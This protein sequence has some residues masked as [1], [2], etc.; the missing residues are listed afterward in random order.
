MATETWSKNGLAFFPDTCFYEFIP[1]QEMLRNL[2]DPSYQPRTY[3]MDQLSANENYELVITVLKGGSFVRY[4]PGDVYRCVRLKNPEDGLDFPQFQYMD[5][6]PTVIDI[7]GFTR[8][9]ENS[10]NHVFE[11]SGIRPADWF[12]LKK[13]D[14][15]KRSYLQMYVELSDEAQQSA[16]ACSTVLREHL[17][18][19]FKY[20]DSDYEDLKAMLGIEPL[21]VTV[22]PRG[23][24]ARFNQKLPFGRPIR[25]INPSRQDEIEIL[26]M[27]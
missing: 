7:A 11:L 15:N 8:I 2:E 27:L 16:L 18:I 22:L 6:I 21:S 19:Y 23:T 4:R 24:L 17:S 12:A 5:R 10:I 14:D 26:R 13:Y 1:E 3:L 9:T 25:R 20:Y